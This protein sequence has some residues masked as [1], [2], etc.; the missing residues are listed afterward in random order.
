MLLIHQAISFSPSRSLFL[1]VL[2]ALCKIAAALSGQLRVAETV[3]KGKVSIKPAKTKHPAEDKYLFKRREESIQMKNLS[4]DIIKP[5]EASRKHIEGTT[6]KVKVQKRPAEE[7]N[8]ENPIVKKK[9]KIVITTETGAKPRDLPPAVTSSTVAVENVPRKPPDSELTDEK[10]LINQKKDTSQQEVDFEKVELQMLTRDLCSLALNPFHG[11][12]RSCPAFIKQIFLKF[13]SLVYQKSLVLAP[14]LEIE[15][16]EGNPSRLPGPTVEKTSNKIVRTPS[17]RPDDPTKG[18]KKRGLSDRPEEVKKK[19]LGVFEGVKRKKV[20]ESFD[21][22]KKKIDNPKFTEERKIIQRPSVPQ[23]KAVKLEGSKRG[24]SMARGAKP[25]MLIMKFPAGS[26]LP[27]G[28]ELKAKFARFGP[29]DQTHT[30]IFWKTYTCRLVYLHKIDAQAALDAVESNT[31]FGNTNVRCFLRDMEVDAAAEPEPVK[32]QKE[33]VSV[34]T[35]QKIPTKIASQHQQSSSGQLKSIL[36]K[37]PGDEGGNGGGRA[38]R[39]KFVLGGDDNESSKG[40]V[41]NEMNKKN[42]VANIHSLD[43]DLTSK[44]LPNII[45]PQ[46]STSSFQKFPYSEQGSRGPPTPQM[47]NDISKQMLNLLT[48]CNEVVNNLRATWGYM[49]YHP[50]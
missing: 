10:R 2:V 28:Y 8:T 49:P 9:K 41:S 27:S 31:L 34:G 25:T 46:S 11:H 17:L 13:R 26:A 5:P 50:L 39:V 43:L 19:K 1:I 23:P 35:E 32:V 45:K 20:D 12:Q 40:E 3:A 36:K 47:N 14:S 42:N 48:R 30:R 33:D 38:A 37:Q 18:G 4:S 44:M 16:I 21:P 15:T 22:K 6:K 29:I 24:E 7:F